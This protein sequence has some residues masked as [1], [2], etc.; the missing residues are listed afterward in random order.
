M[1]FNFTPEGKPDY[2][3]DGKFCLW[4]AVFHLGEVV[5]V[6]RKGE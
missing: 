5:E 3:P 4:Q 2:T 6:D 1:R